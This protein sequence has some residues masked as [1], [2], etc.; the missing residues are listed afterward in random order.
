MIFN[1]SKYNSHWQDKKL[2][3]LGSFRRGKSRHR[4]RNDPKLFKN[5]VYPLVQTGEVKQASLYLNNHHSCYN[6]FGLSQSEIW[7]KNTLCIT[8]AANI[9]ETAL[10]SYPMCFPDSVVGFNAYQEE[11]SEIFMHYVFTYIRRAI[12]NSASG[13]IQDNINVDYLTG[14]KFKVPLKAYQDKIVSVLSV[15]DYKIDLNNRINAELEAMAKTL[16]DYWFVQFDFPDAN[17]K[18]YKTS[19][20]KMVYNA[21]LKREVPVGWAVNTLSQIANITMG[22]SPAGESYN[23]DGIGTLFFQGSTDFGWLFPTPRKY[24]TSPAR[25]AKKGDILL[26]VRAPV[27]DMNIANADCCIGRGLAALNSKSHSDGFLFYVMKYFKQIFDRRNAEGTT[28]G[29]MTKD[30]L[31]SLQV[32]CP[33]PGLLKRYDDIVS[34]YNKMIFTRSLENQDLIKL[35]DWLLPLLMNG[36]ITV[37]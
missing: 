21:T 6:E 12:Q 15:L 35:R 10:L 9:A 1:S 14:L 13:S 16:Y 8:I 37:K 31:H 23:E 4:P 29:S 22:Q 7:P 26:S 3:D 19:G 20:G 32:V 5:G 28:F 30:D 25:M 2:S 36:Q 24:T 34:E 17:G 11:S 18:P 27:G 33:E